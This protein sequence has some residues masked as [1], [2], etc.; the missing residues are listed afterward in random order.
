MAGSGFLKK[1]S[2]GSDSGLRD[3]N[4]SFTTVY[5]ANETVELGSFIAHT[6]NYDDETLP[7]QNT[8]VHGGVN[9]S[10]TF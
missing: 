10:H 1:I 9:I 6:S 4:V 8:D 2:G 3:W 7:D 5:S